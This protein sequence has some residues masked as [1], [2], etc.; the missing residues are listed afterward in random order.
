MGTRHK[1]G[2][3]CCAQNCG[4]EV[5]VENNRIVKVRPDKDNP[6][7]EGYVCRKGLK[8]AHYQHHADRLKRPLK[9]DGNG[10]R[11]IS[12][13]QA[14]DEIGDTLRRLVDEHGPRSFAYMGGG[15]QGCHFEPAFGVR[16]LRGL[17]S[18][19]HY[20]ALAQELTGMFWVHGRAFGRQY[21]LC[22]PDEHET[23]V[24]VALGWNGWMSH[25]MAQARRHLKRISEDPDKLLVVIDP[26]NSETARRADIHLPIRPGTDSLLLKAIIALIVQEGR[27]DTSYISEHVRGFQEVL[28][29]FERFD[30]KRAIQVCELDFDRVKDFSRILTTRKWS[31]HSDLGI[32]M[33]RH[34]TA[35][36]YLEVILMA[37]CGRLGRRGGNI[38]P[39]H[40]MPL[41]SHSDERD[42]RT[43]RTVVT[44]FPAI[45][46]T[47]PPNV[48]PEEIMAEGPDRLRAVLVSG[49]NPLR[50]YADT[51]AYEK[52][53]GKL[54][55][56]VTIDTAMSETAALS[57]YVLPAK[58][59][60]E[61]WDGTFFTWTYPGVYFQMRRPVVEAE[62]DLREE[63]EIMTGLADRL[64]LLPQI[65]ESLYEAARGD[66][67]QYGMA[68]MQYARSEPKAPKV[69]PFVLAKTLGPVLGSHNLAAFWGLLQT[70][71]GDFRKM[72]A[73][74]GFDPGMGM[75]EQIFQ[76]VLEKPEGLWI[77]Q[78]DPEDGFAE[79]KTEDKRINLLIPELADWIESIDP[80][81]EEKDLAPNKQYPLILTAGRHFDYNANTI[82]RNPE[83]N[84]G[85]EGCTLLIHPADAE[86]CG[87]T[88]RG[89]AKVIT[90]A[91]EEV[92]LV[93]I[94][95]DARAGHVVIAHGFGLVYQGRKHG[96]NVNRLTKNTHRDRLAATPYHRYVPCRVEPL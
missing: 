19:Y 80:E 95:D 22:L 4:L 39:G 13:D 74:A 55:L 34:S 30:A 27:Q 9:R 11:G 5:E 82:M 70:A 67:M 57:H 29:W 81:S 49:A 50:S 72:A 37:I 15:G 12:W 43:W 53:F 76:A 21:V 91:G 20:S 89:M 79:I 40:L 65:P 1:T 69:L 33:N 66:R 94:T 96:A 2:C 84:D 56:S 14:L 6:K 86:Q 45:M 63:S 25:Q 16:L 52:A 87:L 47:F 85:K 90:E 28:P 46:G 71:P 26:R 38:F 54:D 77:G 3:I 10:F 24:L 62:E 42:E 60:Y 41:G 58:S 51:T 83:W 93:E 17:G 35:T 73:R 44:N 7:S 64:G 31:M 88:D 61:K 68:L 8:I 59:A 32:L 75:G 18:R 78:C 92:I 48:M 23:D 36:S